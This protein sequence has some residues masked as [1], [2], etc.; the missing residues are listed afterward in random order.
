[1]K[2]FHSWNK[3]NQILKECQLIVAIRPGFRPSDINPEILSKI[4]FANVPRI[5]ISSSQIRERWKEGKTIR[6]MVTQ[7]VWEYI[8]DNKLY[9]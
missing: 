1:M 7:Q 6:Y 3:P 5:E 2:T 9:N 8:N 4:Q